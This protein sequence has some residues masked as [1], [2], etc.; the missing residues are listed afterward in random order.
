[1]KIDHERVSRL[2]AAGYSLRE[3]AS[4]LGCS[5]E[6]VRRALAQ[7]APAERGIVSISAHQG[8]TV[9]LQTSGD[10][11]VLAVAVRRALRLAGFAIAGE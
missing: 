10:P 4:E 7:G 8:G 5:H 11:V 9:K 1:M 2:A 6:G 3:I